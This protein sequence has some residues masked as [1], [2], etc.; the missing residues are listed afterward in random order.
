MKWQENK[1]MIAWRV[2]AN[3]GLVSSADKVY[4]KAP[5]PLPRPYDKWTKNLSVVEKISQSCKFNC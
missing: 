3:A 1:T 4:M 2:A 5:V